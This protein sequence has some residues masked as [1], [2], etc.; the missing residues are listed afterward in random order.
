[1]TLQIGVFSIGSIGACLGTVLE[2]VACR[3]MGISV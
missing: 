2:E 3:Q 1:V